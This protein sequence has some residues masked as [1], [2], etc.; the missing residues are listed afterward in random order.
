M[1]YIALIG[2][3][4]SGKDTSADILLKEHPEMVFHRRMALADPL[5]AIA[6]ILFPSLSDNQLY[7]GNEHKEA[8]SRSLGGYSPRETL[9]GLGTM[10][11]QKLPS[12]LPRLPLPVLLEASL[13]EIIG[14]RQVLI[15]DCRMPHETRR[16]KELGFRF[17]G[18]QR[19]EAEPLPGVVQSHTE[20]DIPRLIR[21]YADIVID[22]DGTIEE[23][24]EKLL[25][26]NF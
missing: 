22:N 10:L 9:I 8:P 5:K 24:R 3:K 26:I 20:L 17:I 14:E 11:D 19:Q 1:K 21:E 13:A 18:I 4:R 2:R 25:A 23:L 15:T 12:I 7:G 6:R 16:L